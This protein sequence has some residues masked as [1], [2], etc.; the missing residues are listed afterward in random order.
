MSL[1]EEFDS[2]P[3]QFSVV[4]GVIYLNSSAETK[5]KFDADPQKFIK[6]A[7]AKW[8]KMGKNGKSGS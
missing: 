2:D 4:D 7:N 1:G 5:K 8:G 6:A 3:K